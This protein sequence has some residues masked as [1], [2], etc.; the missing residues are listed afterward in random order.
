MHKIFVTVALL[1]ILCNS[2]SA[3][4]DPDAILGKWV[5]DAGN[6]LVEV[7][8]QDAE[9]RAKVLWF[10]DMG[11]E[12]MNECL[13]E[14]NPDKSLRSRKI[15]G[16]EVLR[17]LTF[18]ASHNE[19]VNGV[20]YDATCGKEWDSVAWLTKDNLLKVKGY[21]LFRWLSKTNTFKRSDDKM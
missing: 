21:W 13:D 11:K 10:D 15:I 9:Y 12:P 4:N 8:K 14:K 2:L 3:Q 18:N 17:D 19:W 7:Y 16:M 1:G 20:I 5:T 6:C